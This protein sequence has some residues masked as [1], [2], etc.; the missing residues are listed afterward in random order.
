MKTLSSVRVA[1][2]L[3]SYRNHAKRTRLWRTIC[4]SDPTSTLLKVWR[5]MR[6]PVT[7]GHFGRTGTVALSWRGLPYNLCASRGST[8]LVC[9][10]KGRNSRAALCR[11]YSGRLGVWSKSSSKRKGYCSSCSQKK[12]PYLLSL[13]EK[14]EISRARPLQTSTW[15]PLGSFHE[16]RT[17]RRRRTEDEKISLFLEYSVLDTV[18]FRLDKISNTV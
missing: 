17:L 18:P 8:L 13:G 5:R 15:R 10:L 11:L 1:A 14:A 16:E 9:Q 7:I 6:S 3:L 2:I 12:N 4:A